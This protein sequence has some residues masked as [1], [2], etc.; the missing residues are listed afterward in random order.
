MEGSYQ[1]FDKRNE[2]LEILFEREMEF[3]S[4]LEVDRNCLKFS[5]VQITLQG[6]LTLQNFTKF[7]EGQKPSALDVT[8]I[9]LVAA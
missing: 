2:G 5:A 8:S 9:V 6:R 3:V 7:L 4:I 1:L